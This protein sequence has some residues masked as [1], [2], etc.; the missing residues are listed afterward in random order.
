[1]PS[2]DLFAHSDAD[3]ARASSAPFLRVDRIEQAS[4]DHVIPPARGETAVWLEDGSFRRWPDEA[5][6]PVLR[7]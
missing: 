5:R 3:D 1:M 7:Q 6:L 4:D 2:P